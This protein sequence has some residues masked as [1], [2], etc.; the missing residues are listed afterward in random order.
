MSEE[1]NLETKSIMKDNELVIHYE[2]TNNFNICFS[3]VL[4]VLLQN[5]MPYKD[6]F[7]DIIEVS[8]A[9]KGI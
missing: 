6:P 2:Y 9:F 1:K 8:Y 7:D 3:S 4:K 5:S